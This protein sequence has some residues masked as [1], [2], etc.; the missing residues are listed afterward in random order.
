M[1]G[2]ADD[3]QAAHALGVAG[4]DLLELLRRRVLRGDVLERQD[5]V[6][7]APVGVLDD[8]VV[9]ILLRLLAG[10]PA[11]DDAD[12]VDAELLALRLAL[13]LGGG[14]ALRG[15][16]ERGARGLQEECIAIPDREGLADR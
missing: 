12:G 3:G 10:R 6:D 16:V 7:R 11:G 2:I 4:A 13:G 9:E 8:G 1:I 15:L 14:D 5:V